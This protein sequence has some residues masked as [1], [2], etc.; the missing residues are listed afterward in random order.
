MDARRT[1]PRRSGEGWRG[2]V[3]LAAA[4]GAAVLALGWVAG[5]GGGSSGSG[6]STAATT[7]AASPLSGLSADEVLQRTRKAAAA[8]DSVRVAGQV[9]TGNQTIKLDLGLQAGKGAAGTMDVGGGSVNLVVVGKDVYIKGNDAFYKGVLGSKWNDQVAK[10]LV[11]RYIKS[12]T[13][14]PNFGP[15]ALFTDMHGFLDGLLKP[16][17]TVTRVPGRPVDGVA[18]VGLKGGKPGNAAILLVSD[19]AEPLP[20][21]LAPIAGPAGDEITLSNWN[22][23]VDLATPTNDQ[24]FDITKLQ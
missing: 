4:A 11:G 2:R 19:A 9:T 1:Q 16:G 21:H 14:D 8:A 22:G 5:C 6:G 3:L 12:T 18:T 13:D 24:V 23:T 7:A 17:G 20:L 15:I 10:L